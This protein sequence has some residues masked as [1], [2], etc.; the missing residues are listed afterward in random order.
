MQIIEMIRVV[1][2]GPVLI[3]VLQHPD[4]DFGVLFELQIK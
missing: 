1:M 4:T 2:A 3:S